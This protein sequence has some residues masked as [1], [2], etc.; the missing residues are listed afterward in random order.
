MVSKCAIYLFSG[1]REYFPFSLDRIIVNRELRRYAQVEISGIGAKAGCQD[2]QGHKISIPL[3]ER[4]ISRLIAGNTGRGI[5]P[6]RNGGS[7]ELN[8]L[9][10]YQTTPYA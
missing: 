1:R 9:E 2:Y 7:G 6:G 5:S 3:R 8:H 10:I 4:Y